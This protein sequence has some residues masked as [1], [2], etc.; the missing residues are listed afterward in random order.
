MSKS[1][2]LCYERLTEFT[3]ECLLAAGLDG[4]DAE[5]TARGICL[6]S[7]RGIDSHGIRLLPH[8]VKC[9]L[10]GRINKNP[11][12]KFRS[13]LP[14]CHILDADHGISYSAGL[15]AMEKCIDAA[16]RYGAGITAVE[17]SNHCG[18]MAFYALEAAKKDMIGI[19]MTHATPKMQSYGSKST[20]FGTNPVCITAPMSDEEPFCYDSAPTPF[21]SNKVK[22]YKEAGMPLPPGCAADADGNETLDA[23]KAV[24]LLPIG[25]YKG[26]G[27]SMCVDIFC[28]M[29]TG[30]PAGNKVSQMYGT[31]Y[32][33]KRSL[34]QFYMAINI[35]AFRPP[36]EFK[37]Q[38]QKTVNELRKQ[39]AGDKKK[40]M[41]PGDPEKAIA[42]ERLENGIPVS[43]ALLEELNSTALELGVKTLNED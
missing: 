8:Y 15:A 11:V 26:V 28:A 5:N 33:E 14:A 17:N 30:M 21:T 4:Q 41:A 36:A 1:K 24:Q 6:A 29:F 22:M 27:L 7:L 39:P 40:V 37:K 9:I 34:G 31:D 32:A 3:R 12:L 16:R 13:S 18:M 23:E 35:E 25:L 2:T 43:E 20:F 42:R 38:L 19:A 10:G